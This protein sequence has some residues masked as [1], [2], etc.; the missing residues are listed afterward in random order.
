M[1]MR[2]IRGNKNEVE[3]PRFKAPK[4]AKI[5]SGMFV[6]HCGFRAFH[7]TTKNTIKEIKHFRLVKQSAAIT[8][9]RSCV[10]GTDSR[11]FAHT[12]EQCILN[13]V[14]THTFLRVYIPT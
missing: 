8:K 12:L 13:I 10:E 14:R 3:I 1:D 4:T 11:F 9:G 2:E 6:L 7:K 5:L